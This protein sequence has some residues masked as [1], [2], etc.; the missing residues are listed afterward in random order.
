MKNF[1][2]NHKD[3]QGSEAED[4]KDSEI[5][6]LKNPS[7]SYQNRVD[8]KQGSEAEDPKA[9][10]SSRPKN[11]SSPSEDRVNDIVITHSTFR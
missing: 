8:D 11:P 3:K 2:D 7:F 1:W 4:S 6:K 10:E 9:G 5:S